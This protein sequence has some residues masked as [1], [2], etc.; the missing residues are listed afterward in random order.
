MEHDLPLVQ[1]EFFDWLKTN[2]LLAY[3]PALEE[4]GY[5]DL[6]SLTIMTTEEIEELSSAINMKPGLLSP[7]L[8]PLLSISKR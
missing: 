4:Q 7:L 2:K 3:Q 6:F 8:S 5:Q 1:D